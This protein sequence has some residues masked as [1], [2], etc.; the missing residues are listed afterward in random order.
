MRRVSKIRQDPAFVSVDEWDEIENQDTEPEDLTLPKGPQAA[1]DAHSE[2]ENDPQESEG[3]WL[4]VEAAALES[5]E[6]PL[7]GLVLSDGDDLE[8]HV[9][10]HAGEKESFECGACG[11]LFY[12]VTMFGKHLRQHTGERPFR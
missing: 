1:H 5:F 12:D 4:S 11:K 6:C 2:N 8:Q 3:G 10:V 7:C 9:T